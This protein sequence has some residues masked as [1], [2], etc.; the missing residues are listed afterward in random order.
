M[1]CDANCRRSA[2]PAALL[3]TV[4][5]LLALLTS[6]LAAGVDA[7]EPP[8]GSPAAQAVAPALRQEQR[9]AL[10]IGNAAYKDA[11]LT[12]PVN[13]A[14]AMAAALK[15]AGFTVLLHTDVDRR[16]LMEAVRDFGNRLPKGGIGVFYFAGHGMQIKGRNYLI[17]VAADIQREDEV[18]YAALD[19][20][21]VLDKMETAGNGTNV[22]I[23]DACRNNPFARSFRSS[24][25]GL[26]QM[27]APVGTLVAFAT[28]P[29]SVASDGPSANGLYTQ[30]LLTAMREPGAKIE[31]VFKKVRSAVRRD[32]GG[33]QIP[34]ETTSLE[35]DIYLFGPP[36]P[37]AGSAEALEE[38]MWHALNASLDPAELRAYLRRYPNGRHAAEARQQ[39]AV[40]ESVAAPARPGAPMAAAPG[41]AGARP[42]PAAVPAAPRDEASHDRRTGELL[43]ELARP[44][45]V[46]PRRPTPRPSPPRNAQGYAVGDRWNYQVIDKWRGEVVRNTTVRVRSLA[47]DG[48]WDDGSTRFD[49]HGR[50]L[51]YFGGDKLQRVVTPHGARW[52]PEMAP[53]ER[54]RFDFEVTTLLAGGRKAL[55]RVEGEVRMVG[56]ETVKV[57]AGD[58][59]AQRFEYKGINT[60]VSASGRGTI[61]QTAWYAPELHTMV[62]YERETTWNGKLDAREREE[63]TSYVLVG[64]PGGR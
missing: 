33:Q 20:Q 62:A 42:P 46:E 53:G 16:T 57:P 50:V 12:N 6:L 37:A 30:H 64:A 41:T 7:A 52:W 9:L 34:W 56:I 15:L 11:P 5:A 13:D 59:Q 51:S 27:D 3:A 8:R 55:N 24:M 21:A 35:G 19:A 26:A 54:R 1:R 23:L 36:A 14:R 39:L 44:A 38:A 29:G 22:M 32:S 17:P 61:T 40:F 43:A 60:A 45:G 48:S 28:A 4:A 10:V 31:D 25:Q 58:F 49:A 63:L 18:A 2:R 47:P